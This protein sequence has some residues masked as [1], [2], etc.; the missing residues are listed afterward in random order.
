MYMYNK[1]Y[2]YICIILRLE[3]KIPAFSPCTNPEQLAPTRCSMNDQ[4]NII[5]KKQLGARLQP[6]R[7]HDNFETTCT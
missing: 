6:A 2:I 4:N 1:Q 5:N 7:R 3:H